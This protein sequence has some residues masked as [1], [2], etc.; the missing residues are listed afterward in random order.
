M[1]LRANQASVCFRTKITVVASCMFDNGTNVAHPL[2]TDLSKGKTSLVF[3]EKPVLSVSQGALVPFV[4][5]LQRVMFF[6][7]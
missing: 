6:T 1:W 4:N 2:L 7:F 3:P 5:G